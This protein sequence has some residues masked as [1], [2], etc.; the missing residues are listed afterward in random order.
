MWFPEYYVAAIM[1][2]ALVIYMLTGGAD[3][4]GGVWDLL[5]FGSRQ[6]A[7]R[8]LIATALAPIWEA[9][10]IWLIIVVVLMFVAFPPAF[11]TLCIALHVPLTIMLFGI[12]LRGS[13]FVFRTYDREDLKVQH[14]WGLVFAIGSI[15]T[16][17]MLGDALGTLASGDI[18]VDPKTGQVLSGFFGP[19]LKAFPLVVGALTLVLCAYLAAIYLACETEDPDLQR[20]FRIRAILSA[21]LLGLVSFLGLFIAKTGATHL[22]HGLTQEGWSSLFQIGTGLVSI[23]AFWALFTKRNRWARFFAMLQA[24]CIISGWA[25]AQFPYLIV[26]SHSIIKSAAPHSVLHPLLLALGIG[27]VVLVP[28][29][30]YLYIIFK[31]KTKA[32][33]VHVI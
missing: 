29:F 31:G 22:Y 14:R 24:A 27:A 9:N 33:P 18:I 15:I 13:A 28:S 1:Y 17:F 12:V 5:A 30:A 19:W 4:G 21:F 11:A 25:F 32:P 23:L 8:S 20:A 6:K 10:H 16:P 7:Q 3:F 2:I 26:P